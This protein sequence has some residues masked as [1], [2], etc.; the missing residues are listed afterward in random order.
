MKEGERQ[1]QGNVTLESFKIVADRGTIGRGT[2]GEVKLVEKEGKR[3]A[4]K[5]LDKE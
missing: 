1:I 3:Y 4:M 5:T 2:Y